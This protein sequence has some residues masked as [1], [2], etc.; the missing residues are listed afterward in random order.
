MSW[1][2]H[3]ALNEALVEP[4]LGRLLAKNHSQIIPRTGFSA[5]LPYS[6]LSDSPHAT[7]EGKSAVAM[8]FETMILLFDDWL[9]VL[10]GE[11]V[12][13]RRRSTYWIQI[14]EYLI[15]SDFTNRTLIRAPR[16][17]LV[18]VVNVGYRVPLLAK[19]PLWATENLSRE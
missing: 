15:M 10:H 18:K 3:H 17:V 7:S 16:E 19:T 12:P 13:W 5:I 4:T 8:A 14:S 2:T 9:Y 1:E 6:K 11:Q